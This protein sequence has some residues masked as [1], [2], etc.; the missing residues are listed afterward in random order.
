[1]NQKQKNKI[2]GIIDE[3]NDILA[4]EGDKLSNMEEKFSETEKYQQIEEQKD[5]LQ[6]AI[7][8]LESMEL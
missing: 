4:E 1:M 3:L 6:E 2:T 5:L 7:S 8:C